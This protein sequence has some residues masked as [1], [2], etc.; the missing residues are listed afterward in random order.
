MASF[1][2]TCT[3]AILL[4]LVFLFSS[5]YVPHP[6]VSLSFDYQ[7]FTSADQKDFKI[8]GDASFSV[9]LIDISANKL[10]GIGQSKGRVSYDARPL[11]LWDKATGEVASFTTRFN[12]TINP[13]SINNKG[14]GMA[15]FLAGYPSRLPDKCPAYTFGLTNQNPNET[16]SG[17]GRFVAVEFDTFNDTIISDPNTTYDHLGIDVNSLRSVQTLTLPSFSL[18]G[19]MSAQIEYDNVSSILA[20][21]LWLGDRRDISYNLSSK[22][23]LKSALPE[24]V[25]VGFAGATS[26]SVELHQLQSWFFNSSLEPPPEAVLPPAAPP[27]PLESSGRG[28]TGSGV[29]AGAVTGAILFL[30]LLFATAVLV[31]RRR[32]QNKEMEEDDMGSEGD[33]DGEPIMEIEMGMGPRRFPYHELV[34][35]TRNFAAGEKLGQGGFGAVYRGQLREPVLAVAIKRFS[36]ESSMQGKKEYTSEIK[37]ISRLRHRNLVQLVGWCHHGRELLLVYE[38]MPNRSLDIHLHGKGTF[39][40]WSIRM[41]IILGLGSALLYLHEEWEQCVVHRDIKPSN[42]MLDESFSAKLGD[43]GLARLMDHTVGIQTMTAISGT[44]GYMDSQCVITGRA[45]AESDVY[46]FGVVLLEV[47]CGKRPL[48]INDQKNN[49]FH[50]AEWVWKLYGQGAIIDAVD[51]RLDG[52]YDAVEAERVMV[53]GLWCAHP[54]P[55][56]RPSMRAAM[57]TLQSKDGCPL[58]VLPG[59]M[60]VPMYAAPREDGLHDGLS[61]ST[62]SSTAVTHTSSSSSTSTSTAGSNF[63]DSSSLLKHQY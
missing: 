26:T 23:D 61:L 35:A 3:H 58:P 31:V 52:E 59:K 19:N 39:L 48:S 53:V 32:R 4:V 15:F 33:E 51:A 49:V 47:S 2:P 7:T 9:G 56:A 60:P 11:L 5:R 30:L 46:S 44:P 43:F 55:S 62:S 17:D 28:S 40:T 27:P 42:V 34:D 20:L 54:D 45:S 38:L 25:A 21:T 63:K 57:A 36:K 1:S 41:K 50:L 29:I 16:A 22:V 18:M 24:Q 37:V 8:E 10:S 12:F 13:T 14:T 6:A